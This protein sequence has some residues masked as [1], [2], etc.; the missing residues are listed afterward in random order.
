MG[1]T[2][3]LLVRTGAVRVAR[4]CEYLPLTELAL[5]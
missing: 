3:F 1:E 2:A 5:R 4:R